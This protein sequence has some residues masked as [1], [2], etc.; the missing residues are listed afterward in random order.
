MQDSP[1]KYFKEGG[2]FITTCMICN[3]INTC[4]VKI[5]T[6]QSTYSLQR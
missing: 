4:I 6:F 3:F 5:H 1:Q 2:P